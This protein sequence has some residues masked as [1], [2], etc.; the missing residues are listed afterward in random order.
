MSVADQ[1]LAINGSKL[2]VDMEEVFDNSLT[3]NPRSL[4]GGG[5][6]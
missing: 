4:E 2:V 5:S 1:S 3:F 6:N